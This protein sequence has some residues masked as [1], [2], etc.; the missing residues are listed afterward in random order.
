MRASRGLP[1]SASV[2]AG[3]G[4][5]EHGRAAIAGQHGGGNE[6][7]AGRGFRSA[8]HGHAKQATQAAVPL[9][10]KQPQGRRINEDGLAPLKIRRDTTTAR[11]PLRDRR[12]VEARQRKQWT[13]SLAAPLCRGLATET[14]AAF[15]KHYEAEVLP[16]FADRT[17]SKVRTVFDLVEAIVR[18]VK[19]ADV[20]AE[21]L[22]Y[23]QSQLAAGVRIDRD[24][25]KRRPPTVRAYLAA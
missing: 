20:T 4:W 9:A 21:R 19:L 13:G 14:W 5:T 23:F 2:A 1:G 10:G 8:G 11:I 18:P 6:Q 15:R 24:P 17:G 7:A 25:R 12:V 22:S 3:W 16:T